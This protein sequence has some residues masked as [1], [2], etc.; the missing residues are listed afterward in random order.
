MTLPTSTLIMLRSVAGNDASRGWEP[1]ARGGRQPERRHPVGWAVE[2]AEIDGNIERMY[3][4]VAHERQTVPSVAR[5]SWERSG[6]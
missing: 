4:A 2:E 3:D 6:C 5:V 1:C